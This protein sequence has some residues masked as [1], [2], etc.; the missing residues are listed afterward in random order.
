M[1]IMIPI[2][3]FGKAGGLRVLSELANNWCAMGHEVFFLVHEQGDQ[4]YFPTSANIIWIN[5]WGKQVEKNRD[6]NSG[7]KLNGLKILIALTLGLLRYGYQQDILLANYSFTAFPVAITNKK[8]CKFYYI[9]AYEPEFYKENTGLKSMISRTL[10]KF[11]YRMG[12][13]NIVNAD[14]YRNYK[15]I[16]SD[17][18][19]PPGLDLGIYYPKVLSREKNKEF[20]IGCI[21]RKEEWKGSDDVGAAIKILHNQGYNIKFRVAFNPTKYKNH[22][23]VHPDGDKNL[24]DFYRG[25]DI[26]VAPGQIQLGA[27]HYPVIEAMAC[28]VPVIT[29][30]YYPANDENSFI[31][32]I[33]DPERIAETI[34]MIIGNYEMALL[35]ADKAL[36]DIEVFAWETVS[37]KFIEIFNKSISVKR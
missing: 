21:G 3:N 16:K 30:G 2:F 22:E 33:R 20:V 35:K 1:K 37:A 29:T 28:N 19:I 32:P 17:T 13:N 24:A 27:V 18:V 6:L 23:L 7:K 11:S 9:Q 4:P 36:E 15:E 31:V 14:I 8:K 26:L 12:L 25:L 5:S 34:K 10:S